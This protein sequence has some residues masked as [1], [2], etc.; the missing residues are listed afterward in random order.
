MEKSLKFVI[1]FQV[2]IISRK[3]SSFIFIWFG[4]TW[5]EKEKGR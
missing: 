1:A 3:K 5:K 2:E 4:K